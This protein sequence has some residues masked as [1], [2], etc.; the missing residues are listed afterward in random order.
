MNWFRDCLCSPAV[1]ENGHRVS[2]QELERVE[3]LRGDVPVF[4]H[5]S[6]EKVSRLVRFQESGLLSG[7]GFSRNQGILSVL[8]DGDSV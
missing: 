8:A 7:E 3:E 2:F 5:F 1:L 4:L 6:L